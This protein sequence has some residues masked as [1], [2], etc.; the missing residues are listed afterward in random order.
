MFLLSSSQH[1][2]GCCLPCLCPLDAVGPLQLLLLHI[3]ELCSQHFSLS[4]ELQPASVQ[5]RICCLRM[6]Q[7]TLQTSN[8]A[9]HRSPAHAAL[10]PHQPRTC[11]HCLP[12]F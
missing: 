9:L 1:L 10:L 7:Q 12:A 5:A 3:G 11:R 2:L 4:A 6:M 8:D